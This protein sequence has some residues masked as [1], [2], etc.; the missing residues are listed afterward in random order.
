MVLLSLLD[1]LA[2]VVGAPVQLLLVL[3]EAH[4]CLSSLPD[5]SD[6]N[7]LALLAARLRLVPSRVTSVRMRIDSVWV[8]TALEW[9]RC[10]LLPAGK[11]DP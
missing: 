5:L 9:L 6:R 3:I 8:V 11:L 10:V 2:L 4:V 7:E 1:L